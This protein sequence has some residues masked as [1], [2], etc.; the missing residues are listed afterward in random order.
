MLEWKLDSAGKS[1]GNKRPYDGFRFKNDSL[2][3]CGAFC[4]SKGA[5]ALVYRKDNGNCACCN[6]PPWLF[7]CQEC[8]FYTLTGNNKLFA[9]LG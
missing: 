7:D 9:F 3:Q 5:S 2:L 1:C 4:Q 6:T 8:S